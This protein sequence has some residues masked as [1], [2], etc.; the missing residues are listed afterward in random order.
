MKTDG[1]SPALERVIRTTTIEAV[2]R[3]GA[4]DAVVVGAGAAGALAAQCLTEA[5]LR[6]LVLDAGWP[7]ARQRSF[8]RRTTMGLVRRLSDPQGLSMLP[9]RFVPQARHAISAIGRWRQPI[10]STSYAW[11]S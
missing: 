8:L 2:R 3:P 6:V 9:A 1:S 4:C 5:G 11:P 10:Q 7:A